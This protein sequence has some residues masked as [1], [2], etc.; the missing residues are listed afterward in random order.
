MRQQQQQRKITPQ[1]QEYNQGDGEPSTEGG[2]EWEEFE[3]ENIVE[4]NEKTVV[5]HA[6][7]PAAKH[8]ENGYKE[9]GEKK[10]KKSKSEKLFLSFPNTLD[11]RCLTFDRCF[12]CR[13]ALEVG[14]QRPS[15]GSIG[16][17]KL[18]SEM[19]QRLEKVTANHSVRSTKT[20]EKPALP[21]DDGKVKR[22]EDNRKILL[23]QQLGIFDETTFLLRVVKPWISMIR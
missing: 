18:S 15:P 8:A 10:K 6:P 3:I 7:A 16:K 21:R 20:T 4:S 1:Y 22:L 19:R 11:D 5:N 12:S 13:S 17:L 9:E 2:V 23:E 14:A